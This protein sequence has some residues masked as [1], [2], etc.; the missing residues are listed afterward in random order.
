MVNRKNIIVI[1]GLGLL[2]KNFVKY[3]LKQN[4][5]VIVADLNVKNFDCSSFKED[6]EIKNNL[7]FRELDINDLNS[8]NSLIEKVDTKHGKIDAVINSAYPKSNSYGKNFKIISKDEFDLNVSLH[9]GGYFL[10]MQQFCKY[11]ENNGGGNL[12]NI[13]SIYGSL[14]PRFDLYENTEIDLPIEYVAA[15]SAIIQITKYFAKYYK[16]NNVRINCVSPGG[17]FDSQDKKFVNGYL[18]HCG[19]KGMLSSTD[20]N[21][22]IMFLLSDGSKYINGHNLIID[23]SF[24]L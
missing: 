7:V 17:I 9:L 23:D 15:K 6:K 10:V 5:L 4:N 18:N 12:I 16:K 11:F 24:S 22:S 3:L 8:I 2:G 20:V 13:A 21:E 14:V 19:K 1:G